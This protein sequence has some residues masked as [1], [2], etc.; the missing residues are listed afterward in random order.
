MST[1]Y[2]LQIPRTTNIGYGLYIG[3]HMCVAINSTAIIG[4][5]CNLSP[6]VTIGSNYGRAANIGN[7]VYIGPNVSIVENVD[8]GDGSTIAAGSV[9]VTSIPPGATV[10][11]VPAK[12]IS[13]SNSSRFIRNPWIVREMG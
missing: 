4:D 6:F 7:G 11:G 3:H 10:A 13:C 9:V 12:V 1:K 2:N 8:V 5:N